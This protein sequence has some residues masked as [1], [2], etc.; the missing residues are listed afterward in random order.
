MSLAVGDRV[1]FGTYQGLM[2]GRGTIVRVAHLAFFEG[3]N[4]YD[5][6]LDGRKR[7]PRSRPEVRRRIPQW[8]LLLL[9]VVDEIGRL[10]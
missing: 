8:A 6:R 3:E 7:R 2:G 9:N 4:L 1:E 5:V 10:G